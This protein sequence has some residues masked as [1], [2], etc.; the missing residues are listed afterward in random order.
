MLMPAVGLE[1]TT[2]QWLSG[3]FH[4]QDFKDVIPKH[5]TEQWKNKWHNVKVGP[6][7]HKNIK[8]TTNFGIY[9]QWSELKTLGALFIK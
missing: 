9:G 4:T 3:G 7:Q 5:V 8:I 2:S 1:P 6:L